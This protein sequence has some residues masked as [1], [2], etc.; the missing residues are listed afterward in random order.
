MIERTLK[1]EVVRCHSE[2]DAITYRL[3][4]NNALYSLECFRM[5]ASNRSISNYSLVEDITDDEGDAYDF[6]NRMA[7]G[8]VLPVHIREMAEDYF[9]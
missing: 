4:F 7:K 2:D 1:V 3:I 9:R 5:G 8:K 6:L